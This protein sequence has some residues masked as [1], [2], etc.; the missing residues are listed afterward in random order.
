[1]SETT[2]ATTLDRSERSGHAGLLLLLAGLLVAAVVSLSLLSDEKAQIFIVA[3][4]AVLA[5]AGIF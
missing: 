1:M 4:L 3:F 2:A 5:V